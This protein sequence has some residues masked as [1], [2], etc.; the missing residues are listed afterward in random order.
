LRESVIA[1]AGLDVYEHE[2]QVAPE[3][4]QLDNVVL[5]PHIGSASH[6]TRGKMAEVAAQNVIAFFSGRPL[7][8]PLNPQ[9]LKSA[10]S[11]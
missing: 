11:T 4:L 1:G 7:P 8:T 9:V 2:P 10:A 5:L 6:A 3:L